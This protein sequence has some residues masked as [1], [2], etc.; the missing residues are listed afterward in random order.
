MS[1]APLRRGVWEQA[2]QLRGPETSFASAVDCAKSKK[3]MLAARE[4]D[5]WVL[6]EVK[7]YTLRFWKDDSAE[8]AAKALKGDGNLG[9]LTTC[10]QA[11]L[12]DRVLRKWQGDGAS[13]AQDLATQVRG[14]R[15]L[16]RLVA[17]RLVARSVEL[18]TGRGRDEKLDPELM[19]ARSYAEAALL[20]L[21][22]DPERPDFTAEL[23]T[24]G[25]QELVGSQ[26]LDQASAFA[27]ML[28]HQPR[29]LAAAVSAMADAPDGGSREAFILC[30][31]AQ[32]RE[33]TYFEA[34]GLPLDMG[35]ALANALGQPGEGKRLGEILATLEGRK[36][37]VEQLPFPQQGKTAP[38][39]RG[40]LLGLV[41]QHREITAD[42]LHR[43]PGGDPWASSMVAKP[44]AQDA[45][46]QML[47]ASGGKSQDIE[48]AGSE[49]LE[50]RVARALGLKN[51]GDDG[52]TINRIAASILDQ[53][54]ADGNVTVL[55]IQF[56]SSGSGA[57][58][59]PLFRIEGN[60]GAVRFVDNQG[61]RYADFATWKRDNRLPPGNMTYPRDGV[62]QGKDGQA[63]LESG[64]TPRTPDSLGEHVEQTLDKAALFGGV[65]AAGLMVIGSGGTAAPAVAA[66]AGTWFG[67][68]GAEEM[69]SLRERGL[70]Q[71]DNLEYRNA[72]L[73]TVAGGASVLP[74]SRLAYLSQTGKAPEASGVWSGIN[75]SA[76]MADGAATANT[77]YTLATDWDDLSPDQRLAMGLGVAF[78]GGMTLAMSHSWRSASADPEPVKVTDSAGRTPT[79]GPQ[80]PLGAPPALPHRQTWKAEAGR[81]LRDLP[82]VEVGHLYFIDIRRA[83]AS[84]KG[85]LADGTAL[86]AHQAVIRADTEFR[87]N[88]PIVLHMSDATPGNQR[89]AQDLADTAQAPVYLQQEAGGWM[90]LNP[91]KSTPSWK[92]EV[93]GRDLYRVWPD[94]TRHR[95]EN[96]EGL[97]GPRLGGGDFKTAFAFG[98]KA[99]LVIRESAITTISGFKELAML[100]Q[101]DEAGLPVARPL[102]L[103]RVGGHPA[104]V[105]DR[106]IAGSKD[107]LDR[108][109]DVVVDS[110][111]MNENSL[112]SLLQ[113]KLTMQMRRI[114][115][116]DLQF[117]M[118]DDGSFVIADPLAVHRAVEPSQEALGILDK[119]IDAA[120]AR[121]GHRG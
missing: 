1:L 46:D 41:L 55:L 120:R 62:L 16:A 81:A 117:L 104:L 5:E 96:V 100:N 48:L 60:N 23:D 73:N 42:A 79:E 70:D 105:V 72:L 108:T 10:E 80:V 71:W 107:M 50:S 110:S 35:R 34:S 112:L 18:Q 39:T 101:L 45:A 87:Q 93:R 9:D 4:I 119:L 30:A 98:D 67:W 6:G 77:G 84:G 59:L 52:K 91:S 118:K 63:M 90:A 37:L 54:G 66:G 65:M 38:E 24:A 27:A 94:G 21:G 53:G 115:V 29:A 3:A 40:Q 15:D 116:R 58:Q 74:F 114:D 99:V 17:S 111:R 88:R 69:E 43:S 92:V 83:T 57:V 14:D 61:G 26:P 82:G 85:V 78:W 2:L 33:Q 47:Q 8:I 113:I 49:T 13:S 25:L 68:R 97:L 20:A 12:V 31:F 11:R 109:G 103:I 75:G 32:S 51:K 106:Y 76:I 64:N 102:G 95:I 121:L 22:Y 19:A 86:T 56:S 36:L 28:A 89:F 44:I 7:D